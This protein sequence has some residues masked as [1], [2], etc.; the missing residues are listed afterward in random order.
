ME[1]LSYVVTFLL[2]SF[3]GSLALAFF[4]GANRDKEIYHGKCRRNL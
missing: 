3:C 2:G 4:V 1:I